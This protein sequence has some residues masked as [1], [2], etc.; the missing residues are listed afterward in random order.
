MSCIYEFK[1]KCTRLEVYQTE[2][3]FPDYDELEICMPE[4]CTGYES[5]EEDDF[6]DVEVEE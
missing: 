1:G 5:E 6:S 2:E 3:C 4:N